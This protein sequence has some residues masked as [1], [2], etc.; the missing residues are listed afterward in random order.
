MQKKIL[1]GNDLLWCVAN[2][3]KRFKIRL[4]SV[5]DLEGEILRSCRLTP[6]VN[7]RAYF[8]RLLSHDRRNNKKKT[9]LKVTAREPTCKNKLGVSCVND[10]A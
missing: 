1:V 8:R 10:E 7:C 3:T 5:Y 4:A 9:I 6:E 2:T